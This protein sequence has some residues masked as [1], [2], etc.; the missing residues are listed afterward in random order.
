MISSSTLKRAGAFILLACAVIFVCTTWHWSFVGDEAF[1]RYVN[2]LMHH[3]MAPYRD[4]VDINMPGAY[5]VDWL[6][7]HLFGSGSLAWR[8]FDFT[9]MGLATLAALAIAWPYDWFAGIY[10]GV[11]FMLI[12][13]RDGVAQAG[14]RDLTMSVLLLAAVALLF[15]ARRNNNWVATAFFGLLCG[16]ASIIK[17]TVIPLGFVLLLMLIIDRRRTRL[18][19]LVHAIAGLAGLLIPL[20]LTFLFL[21]RQHA[22]HAFL[23]TLRSLLPYHAS[24][25]RLP[26]SYFLWHSFA[27]E[28]VP[29]VLVWLALAVLQKD[30][31]SW[32]RGVLLVCLCFGLV[33]LIVQGKGFPYHR[34]PSEAFLLLLAGI[35]FTVALQLRGKLQALGLVGLG[36]GVLVLA[37]I[38]TIKAA[39]YQGKTPATSTMLQADLNRLGGRTLSG[40]I[41]CIDTVGGCILTL[42]R[43]QLV[44]STGFL[45]DCYLFAPKP[46]PV[47]EDYRARFWRELQ[48]H[49]PKVFVVTDRLCMNV[50]GSSFDKLEQW[51]RFDAYLRADYTLE[52]QRTPPH[53][54]RWW[55]QSTQPTSYRIYVRKTN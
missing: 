30:R 31:R 35:D 34:Y 24:I 18:P 51:L 28:L 10:A 36:L 53:E 29:I 13:G 4:I 32:E 1:I 16:C 41:Q 27:S 7:V 15:Y 46:S 3:G 45:Y 50:R 49:P 8:I 38:S 54:V 37:P 52:V 20:L 42:N 33:S 23:Y 21:V 11:L 12:H 9:L 43:M 47:Q 40:N 6:V 44:Q 48:A 2:F 39:R 25:G 14:E 17:P 19:I 5:A 26:M 55:N 22:V